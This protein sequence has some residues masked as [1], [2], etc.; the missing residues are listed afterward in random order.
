MRAWIL[1]LIWRTTLTMLTSVCELSL[2]ALII[3]YKQMYF[4]LGFRH[5]LKENYLH[6]ERIH[7]MTVAHI[8]HIQDNNFYCFKM[9]LQPREGTQLWVTRH[10]PSKRPYF[11]FSRSLSP[12]DPHFYQRPPIFNKLHGHRKTLTH[13]CQSKTPHFC[14]ISQTS[15]NFRQKIWFFE[16]FDKYW[17]NGEK[18]LAILA[19]N[20]L[21]AP[22]ISDAFHWKTPYFCTLCHG[23][24][25]FLT[26]FITERPLHLRCLVALVRHFHMWV[27]PP[28]PPPPLGLQRRLQ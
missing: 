11:F 21:K 7:K 26:Q 18:F 24:T 28:S 20:M 8:M 27:P 19:L 1:S 14:I 2:T 16:N 9:R 15:D 17:R 22:I 4:S 23:K 3:V 12:K 5:S 25:P 6:L 13:L 10:V